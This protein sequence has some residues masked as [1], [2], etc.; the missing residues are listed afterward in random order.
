MLTNDLLKRHS[1]IS[2]QIGERALGVVLRELEAVLSRNVPGNIV[3]FG[4]YI[5]TTS[6]FIRRLLRST[7]QSKERQ[8]HAYDSFEGL[9]LKS[10]QDESTAGTAFQSGELSVSKK[11]FLQEFT[12]A[13]LQPP[14]THKGWFKDLPPESVPEQIAF[15]FLDGDFYGSILDSLRLVWP[16]LAP[17]GVITIDDYGREALPGVE[18]AVHDFFQNESIHLHHEQH[19]AIIKPL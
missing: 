18:R 6:L 17:G 2:D 15:A 14:V 11:R 1:I 5:G 3:E 16:R 10:P 12:R 4:C 9:P 8:F 13:G 7:G 19:I